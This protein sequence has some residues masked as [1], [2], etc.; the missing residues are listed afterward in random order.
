MRV[1]YVCADRG[2]PVFGS[3]GASIHVREVVRAMINAGCEVELFAARLGG[4]PASDLVLAGLHELPS[5]SSPDAGAREREA[6]DRNGPLREL[7]ERAGPF[8]LVYE[9]HALWSF[10]GMEFAHQ[11]GIA[12]VLEVNAPLIEEQRTHRTLVDPDAA[13]RCTQRAFSAAG[14]VI[15]VS[16]AILP[17]ALTRG[18]NADHVHVIPNAINVTRFPSSIRP[19]HRL[20]GVFTV[21]FVGS[22]KPWH[23]VDTL[24]D[25]FA[26]FVAAHPQSRLLIVGEGPERARLV[27]DVESLGLSDRV[28]WT[29]AVDSDAVPGLL[30]SMD[31]SV[32]P[33]PP[34]EPFYFSPLKVFESM[35]AGVPVVASRIGQ[36]TSVIEDGVN[37]LLCAPG[38]PVALAAALIRVSEDDGLR[39]RLGAAAREVVLQRYTWDSVVRQVFALASVEN[40]PVVG[41][42]P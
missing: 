18:A 8:D 5:G 3:K 39:Q 22:L 24:I 27:A 9:R 42:R 26:R 41:A 25:A 16:E 19:S 20:E 4:E 38:D 40:A 33:Y 13:E 28:E 2:V 31:V 34:I 23:G 1:A 15:V 17:Y 12:S 7:L 37:G 11:R 30:A 36:I 6:V 21:G 29:G 32:A 10:A 35:A 14:T